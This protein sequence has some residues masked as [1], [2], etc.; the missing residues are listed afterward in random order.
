VEAIVLAGGKAERLGDAAQGKPKPLVPVAGRPLLAYTVER[1]HKA[2]VDRLIVACSAGKGEEFVRDLDGLGVEI[3]P[4]EEPEPLGRGGGIRF[5]AQQRTSSGTILAMNGDELLDVDIDDLVSAHDGSGALATITVFP[6]V[7][8]FGVVELEDEGF[9]TGFTE[10]APRLPHWVNVGL[11]V[12]EEAALERFPEKG[13]HESL[14]FPALAA[15]RKLFAYRHEGT[16]LT[17]N[18]PKQLRAA[19]EFIGANPGWV[20]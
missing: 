17:V 15:E 8:P 5:A 9:V 12:L 13:D 2:G 3:V 19:A 18:T 1:L 10:Q 14:T 16:W 11:Y 6:L 4:V 20:A 7:S